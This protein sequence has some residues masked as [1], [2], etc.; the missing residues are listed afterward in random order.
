V[1]GR[2]PYPRMGASITVEKFGHMPEVKFAQQGDGDGWFYRLP[3]EGRI[4]AAAVEHTAGAGYAGM[5]SRAR[6]R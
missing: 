2:S 5:R 1:I 4:E 3:P 6:P